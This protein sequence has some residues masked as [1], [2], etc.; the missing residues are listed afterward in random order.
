MPSDLDV[1]R[2][3]AR[4]ER[5]VGAA[6]IGEMFSRYRAIIG[7]PADDMVEPARRALEELRNGRTPS[8]AELQAL[9]T[10]IRLQRPAPL[11]QRSQV[12]PLSA[13]VTHVFPGWTEFAAAVRPHLPAVGRIDRAAA[14]GFAAEVIGTGF[15]V[16]PS[17]LVT[18]RHVV[19]ELSLG[20]GRLIPGQAEVRFGGEYG[21]TPDPRPVPIVEVKALHDDLDLALLQLEPTG[22][23]GAPFR[24][25]ERPPPVETAVAAVGYPMP[26]PRNP[27][28]V[29]LLFGDHLGVKRAAPGE[30]TEVRRQWLY[31]DCSTLGGNSGSPVVAL[32]TAALVGVH[33]DGF[34]L[35]RNHALTG[36]QVFDFLVKGAST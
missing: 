1:D 18:N 33:A 14:P 11:V 6:D 31:H 7:P 24:L 15:L 2:L 13:D 35:A 16:G 22:P 9:E 36:T 10:A 32:E 20:T 25:A 27:K 26:D 29:P 34:Y 28:F 3:R 19:D 17:S 30:V 23:A 4:A 5:A 12:A 8:A 21:V